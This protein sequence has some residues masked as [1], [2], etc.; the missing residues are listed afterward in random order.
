MKYLLQ[1]EWIKAS[2]KFSTWLMLALYVALTPIIYIV[3]LNFTVNMQGQELKAVDAFMLNTQTVWEITT[4]FSS[5]IVWFFVFIV[6]SVTA[7]D[8]RHNIWKQHVIE[9]LNRNQLIF[10]K[11]ILISILALFGTLITGLV[12][13]VTLLDSNTAFELSE[14]SVLLNIS[15]R[16]FLYLSGIMIVS[17][18]IVQFLKSSGLTI[19][20]MLGWF[21]IAEPIIR[22]IDKSEITQYLIANSYNDLITNPVTKLFEV[23]D[24]QLAPEYAVLASIVWLSLCVGLS[25]FKVNKSDL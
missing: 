1:N 20:L 24:F 3:F 23:P 4:F 16:Y 7:D 12:A 25:L 9:G 15:A 21:W 22:W 10:A 14:L 19:I 6:V 13:W 17:L 5:Y 11:L 2:N 18:L 8:I